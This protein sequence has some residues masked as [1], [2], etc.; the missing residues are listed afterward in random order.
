M[1]QS[2][3][4]DQYFT[5]KGLARELYEITQQRLND[6]NVEFDCW[7][8]PAAGDGSFFNLLP[9]DRRLGI[10][11]DKRLDDVIEHDFL[12]F[13]DFDGL[14]FVAIG[15]PPFGKNAGLAIRFFNKCARVSNAIAFI[16]PKT[17][18]KDSVINKLDP[19]FHCVESQS[20]PDNSFEIDGV[21]KL[22][23]CVFQIWIKRTKQ[24]QRL[25]TFRQHDDLEFLPLDR[26]DEATILFQ[27]VGVRA[28]TFKDPDTA[29]GKS[30]PSHYYIRC[31]EETAA[32]LRTID[33][34]PTKHNTVGNP[35]ISKSDLIK[36]YMEK[37]Q[38]LKKPD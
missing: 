21:D 19:C 34:W 33:D 35:S 5:K 27:R 38:A 9:P 24:R 11:I 6:L 32:L 10:D 1:S 17:F 25:E 18:N 36:A 4:L 31:S 14:V 16:V 22:V 2:E 8:E 12:T 28:G 26:L 30:P 29:G 23:P 13:N 3:A 37:K 20:L 7:L 15:N